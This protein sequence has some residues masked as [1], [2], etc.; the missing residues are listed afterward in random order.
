MKKRE[1]SLEWDFV[2]G[3]FIGIGLERNSYKLKKRTKWILVLPFM[4]IAFEILKHKMVR[5]TL[6]D[7][8]V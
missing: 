3:I 1:F 2:P 5:A 7:S 8:Q 6:K 4:S